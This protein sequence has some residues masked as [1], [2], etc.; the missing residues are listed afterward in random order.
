M[1]LNV[2]AFHVAQIATSEPQANQSKRNASRKG[3]E[4]GGKARAALLSP[5]RRVEI[6]HNANKARWRKADT[7]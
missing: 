7:Q 2:R 6:A 4:K 1:D 3:G 5:E